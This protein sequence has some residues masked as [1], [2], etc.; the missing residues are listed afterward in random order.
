MGERD[1][2]GPKSAGQ[3][4]PLVIIL[5][6]VLALILASSMVLMNGVSLAQTSSDPTFGTSVLNGESSSRPT[7]L[8][9]GPDKRLYVAQQNGDINAYTV[10]RRGKNDYTVTNMETIPEIKQIPN[11]NDDGT[12]DSTT[13]T[14]ERQ[15]T[16][17]LVTGT[18]AQPVIYATSSDPR[19]G[20][21]E[22]RGDKNLDTNSGVISKLTKT[23]SGWS[24]TDLVRGLPR[25]E[26]NHSVNGLQLDEA[27]NT[28]F[29]TV[30]G[31]TNQGAPSNNFALLPE[32][33]LSAA[34]LTIDLGAI[35]NSTYDL[36]TIGSSPNPPFGGDDGRNQAKLVSAG[37]VQVYSP[38]WRN[39]YDLLVA[40]S[41]KMYTVDNG[42]NRGWGDL[43]I[44]E[45]TSSCTNE[46]NNDDYATNPDQLHYVSGKG[47]YGG[48]PNPTRGNKSNT[49]AG[50]SPVE[51]AAN[52]VECNYEKPASWWDGNRG[53]SLAVF[54]ASTNG[55]TEYTATNFDGAMK[56]DL[57]A[58][59]FNG[60]IY[61]MKLN[62]SG[63]ALAEDK[64]PEF[65]GFGSKPLDVTAQGDE[66]PFPGTVWA[67]VYGEQGGTV[68]VFEPD[69]F[70]GGTTTCDTTDP[71][72]DADGDG[73]TNSDEA[74]NN[75]NPCSA[76]SKPTDADGDGISDKTDPDDDNDGQN[77][78]IDSFALDAYNGTTTG[79]PKTLTFENETGGENAGGIL[80]LGFTGLMTNGTSDYQVLYDPE[81]VIAGG[82]AGV[83]TVE[84]VPEGDAY[85]ATN[86]QQYGLQFGV[87]AATE[88]E[89]FT[90]HTRVSGPF[91]GTT[92][93]ND[94]SMGMFIGT[95]DQDNYL[96]IVATANDGNGGI[97]VLKEVDGTTSRN[98][99]G[100]ASGVDIL[101]SDKVDL[102][103]TVDPA[104]NTVQPSYSVNGGQQT[105][106]GGPIAIPQSW[107]GPQALAVG[108]ISTSV[109]PGAE[110]PAT[111]KFIQIARGVNPEEPTEPAPTEPDPETVVHRVNA[112]G[113][114]LGA[115]TPPWGSDSQVSPST[116]VNAAETGN[117]TFTSTDQIDTTNVP[118]YVPMRLFQTERWDPA[119][120]PEMQWDFPVDPGEYEVRLYFAETFDAASSTGTR[121]FD[122]D[123][124]VEGNTVL[125]DYDVF[126]NAGG[127]DKAVMES[128]SATVE[129]TN[130]D[131]NFAH[132]KQNPA[133]KGIEVIRTGDITPAPGP[134]GSW[135]PLAPS[136]QNRQEVSY[137]EAGGKFYLAGGKTTLHEVYDPQTNSWKTVK[138]L[139]AS[140]DHIQGVEVGG[141]IYYIGG[142][143]GFPGPHAN[144]MYIYDPA[145]DSFTQGEPMPGGRGRGA[146]GV[147]VYAG[148]IYYAGGLH[149][150]SAVP[151]VDEYDPTA[152]SWS[153][154]P[155][156]PR[157]RDHFQA[158]VVDGE[159]YAIGGRDTG[160]NATTAAN[161]SYNLASGTSG[162]WSTDGALLP[163]QRGGFAAAVLGNEILIIGGEGDGKSY[164]QVEAYDTTSN[165]W[166]ELAPMP[167]ARHGIQAAVC[168]GGVYVA[169]GGEVQGGGSKTNVHEAFFLDGV[170]TCEPAQP[171][172]EPNA[173]PKSTA[174][175]YTLEQ[176]SV[177][178]VDAPGVLANDTD[179]DGD[180]LTAKLGQTNVANGTL[181][182]NPNGSFTY[183][184]KQGFVGSDAFTYLA[185]DGQADSQ[186]AKVTIEVTEAPDQDPPAKPAGLTATADV[187]GI[188]LDWSDNQ[189]P[190]L[191]GYNVF[192][193]DSVDGSFTRLNSDLLKN[194][195]YDDAQAP[196]GKTSYYRVTAVDESRN[197]SD[198][199]A[200]SAKRPV[201]DTTAPNTSIT[202]GP[203]GFTRSINARFTFESTEQGSTFK[204]RFE[205]EAFI[206]CTS[207]KVYRDLS[208]GRHVFRV[209]ATDPAGNLDKSAAWRVWRVDTRA[210][211][212]YKFVPRRKIRDRTPTVR[213]YI[214]DGQ[215]NLAK[216]NVR[217]YFDGKRK[218]QFN[219]N[220]RTDRLSYTT[221]SL[222]KKRHSVKIVAIDRAGNRT[223]RLWRFRVI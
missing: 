112:G 58:A 123:V 191:A 188:V 216:R 119:S 203:K 187:D 207:P 174:D 114:A 171:P 177:L 157:A 78:K 167:T 214:T 92:P 104:T 166:R 206:P 42:G 16:G 19:I 169:A 61:R 28:L 100:P 9:F 77:D 22:S 182:L 215:A 71:N 143:S 68:Q 80:D 140:L 36:P 220:R 179:D 152:N 90:A 178:T 13:P 35:G 176:D 25:S 150:G 110:F 60:T 94:Q 56:G 101:G 196:A 105:S 103:L 46:V 170:T 31:H 163:T 165:T 49:F 86:T 125:N 139:P 7:S 84:A 63:D 126:E 53:N 199:A 180:T 67:A 106:L 113:P 204:C 134:P 219:Y 96:K 87:N 64:I 51:V 175:A 147:A 88:T 117:K 189:E 211:R 221:G 122:V 81:N 168:N 17:I 39:A 223:V 108:V 158:A 121:L 190:D 37:P 73:F 38:G 133:V 135:K 217:L 54:P 208:E 26:E 218:G 2:V 6:S 141:K 222:A 115:S 138:P 65:S 151:W 47:Y 74:A 142:L 83:M 44:G 195:R 131:V 160:I 109:G 200:A 161:D 120:E 124:E 98:E 72:E 192:R 95:G 205:R 52:P 5:F 127:H 129:D 15:V 197:K 159:F 212:I 210:P 79:L 162:T 3:T 57:F 33:A 66:D 21:G 99:Y 164:D 10:E 30:G 181:K 132:V 1:L 154:L 149:E 202:G 69:D 144:T 153:Q 118:G 27:S 14:I 75:T 32:Y 209:R 70:G 43:P 76:A 24:R 107:L 41:G 183:T 85:E 20:A 93:E 4:R 194:S 8:Q 148:K 40:E 11:H 145:T 146:G 193:S 62:G 34:I 111:W 155:D 185:N 102:Y 50:V 12:V 130:L 89:P 91:A 18:A 184:P 23:S 48:H 29:L 156:M 59:A 186:E 82:A 198:F 128:I 213:A 172:P 97:E 45:G 116:Y 136:S 137:V 201:K 173:T 55:L